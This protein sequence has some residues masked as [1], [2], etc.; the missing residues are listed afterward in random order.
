MKKS[1]N[2]LQIEN[3]RITDRFFDQLRFE[4][5]VHT[6]KRTSERNPS[7]TDNPISYLVELGEDSLANKNFDSIY[8]LEGVFEKFEVQAFSAASLSYF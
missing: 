3:S 2:L 7:K 1:D 5:I 4:L 8:L 6:I